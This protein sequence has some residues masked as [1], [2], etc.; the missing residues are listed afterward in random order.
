[1]KHLL[2]ISILLLSIPALGQRDLPESNM[3]E[4]SNP[5]VSG[6]IADALDRDL[7]LS[8]YLERNLKGI[9][10]LPKSEFKRWTGT[11]NDG[12]AGNL[13][14]FHNYLLG[15]Y[16]FMILI[17]A[18]YLGDKKMTK[19]FV[20]HEIGHLL[21]LDH[22][23][24]I[25]PAIMNSRINGSFLTAENIERFFRRLSLVPPGK[26]RSPILLGQK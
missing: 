14:A 24:S 1:M 22:D 7:F 20:Y 12:R 18:G 13:V 6:F 11:T 10:F 8:E 23:D 3:P 16:E 2:Y 15:R 21:G 9:Y 25:K 4:I 19:A 5:I 17:D 26:Y